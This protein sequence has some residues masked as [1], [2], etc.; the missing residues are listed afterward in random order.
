M[1]GSYAQPGWYV[2]AL[3]AIARGEFGDADVQE[4]ADDASAIAIDDQERAGLDLVSDG[5]VRRH[6]FI[7]GFYGRLDG[8]RAV[9]PRRRLGAYLY[10]STGHFETTGPVSAPRGLGTVEEF[11]F[12]AGRTSKPVKVAVAGPLTLANAIHLSAGYAGREALLADL[13]QIVRREVQALAAAGCRFIQID[14]SYYQHQFSQR[15]ELIAEVYDAVTVN[16]SDVI[17]GLHVCFGNL[18]G[19]PHSQRTYR[20]VLPALRT[21]RAQ[22]LFLELANREMA[23]LDRW[24]ELD[25]PQILAAGVVD[26][27]S[28]YRERAEDVAERLRQVVNVCAVERVWAVPDC[29]FWETPRWLAFRKLQALVQGAALVREDLKQHRT[30]A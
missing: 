2:S 23:E 13:V 18:R 1:I 28:S 16:L 20:H 3:D 22:V 21:S 11:R 30:R 27:K 19:R 9:P 4:A 12:A 15:P 26:V 6:D 10:D 14:E 7:M 17:L 5:E 25:M 24:R 29:G 8:L